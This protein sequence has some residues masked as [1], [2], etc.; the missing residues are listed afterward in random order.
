MPSKKTATKSAAKTATKRTA[1]TKDE[2]VGIIPPKID[3]VAY[4]Q[5]RFAKNAELPKAI[6]FVK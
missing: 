2:P 3:P 6:R 5:K 4:P 1:T